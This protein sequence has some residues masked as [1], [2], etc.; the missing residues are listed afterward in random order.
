M[1]TVNVTDTIK[2]Y[3]SSS[4]EQDLTNSGGGVVAGG[5]GGGGGPTISSMEFNTVSKELKLSMDDG[6][7]VA[8]TIPGDKGGGDESLSITY[9]SVN[10]YLTFTD[11][12]G[13]ILKI[14][15]KELEEQRGLVSGNIQGDYLFL[16]F[17][18]ATFIK[19]TIKGYV[20]G[21][22]RDEM[23][24]NVTS[25]TYTNLKESIGSTLE[26]KVYSY[27][28]ARKIK[29]LFI[30]LFKT[31]VTERTSILF[32]VDNNTEVLLYDSKN[33]TTHTDEAPDIETWVFPGEIF[34]IGEPIEYVYKNNTDLPV[35]INEL[36][37]LDYDGLDNG[38]IDTE[39]M[40]LNLESGSGDVTN[41]DISEL[42]LG[43]DLRKAKYGTINPNP[44]F[45]GDEDWEQFKT[46]TE[47]TYTDML[48]NGAVPIS[49]KKYGAWNGSVYY[50]LPVGNSIKYTFNFGFRE[51][52]RWIDDIQLLMVK[53]LRPYDRFGS[54]I[55]R[56]FIPNSTYNY[57]K[58]AT[59]APVG[60]TTLHLKPG[61][62]DTLYN[63]DVSTKRYILLFPKQV[64]GRCSYIRHG[65]QYDELSFSRNYVPY[66]ENALTDNGDGTYTLEL[67]RPTQVTMPV[68]SIVA[69]STYTTSTQTVT[70]GYVTPLK[71]LKAHVKVRG[72]RFPYERDVNDW[73]K[74]GYQYNAQAYSK[75]YSSIGLV[76]LINE[77][78]TYGPRKRIEDFN[79]YYGRDIELIVA[80]MSYRNC[81]ES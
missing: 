3:D 55:S 5:G 44:Y 10:D 49:I 59:L 23:L 71:G 31:E 33:M 13:E 48:V 25:I 74:T 6:S 24:N 34:Y 58:V 67:T 26:A 79:D 14:K 51:N 76:R 7:S 11:V 17:N 47:F 61:M 80:E 50:N 29:N 16:N 64:D 60:A 30:R 69:N 63:D 18:D 19:I 28:R 37:P 35:I 66:A 40:T 65:Y 22:I 75:M 70:Y 20:V 21:W 15:P 32:R 43:D 56:L 81:I 77:D 78:G 9:D 36:L 39:N 1:S 45:E 68:D 4:V 42:A 73:G 54:L 8:V 2:W 38:N 12:N 27:C 53:K 41:I 72:V 52:G 57:M 46:N 62:G